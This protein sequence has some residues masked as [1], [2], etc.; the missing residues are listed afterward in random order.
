MLLLHNASQHS[1]HIYS[2]MK[3]PR[4][5]GSSSESS[6]GFASSHIVATTPASSRAAQRNSPRVTGLA[7][8]AD[9]MFFSQRRKRSDERQACGDQARRSRDQCEGGE[10]L[11]DFLGGGRA[12]GLAA[13][14]VAPD[15]LA[16]QCLQWGR[17]AA[18]APVPGAQRGGV[19]G[20]GRTGKGRRQS[21]VRALPGRAE[22]LRRQTTSDAQERFVSCLKTSTRGNPFIKVKVLLDRV[23]LWDAEQRPLEEVRDLSNRTC[24][25]R[26]E[27]KQV[28]MMSGQCGLLIEVTDLMLRDEEPQR[29]PF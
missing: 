16:S 29:C 13:G 17:D 10:V 19:R 2:V 18:A 15:S 3:L 6:Q 28:W 11:P 9:G 21:A 22:A 4:R 12:G 8:S 7:R 5:Q 25:L 14:G 23:C 24:K 26:A 20:T 27:L 1:K